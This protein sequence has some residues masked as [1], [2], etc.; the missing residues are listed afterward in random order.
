M[1]T[2]E[3]S[4]VSSIQEM[5]E[6]ISGTEDMIVEMRLWSKK[7]LSLKTKQNKTKQNKTKQKSW[8]KTAR[9]SGTL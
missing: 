7:M 8:H 3:A 4:L 1:G 2:S 9:K 5:E 6:R